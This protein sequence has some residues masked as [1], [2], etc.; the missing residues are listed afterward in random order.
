ML[1]LSITAYKLLTLN[2]G[3]ARCIG[4][5]TGEH[6]DISDLLRRIGNFNSAQL[7]DSVECVLWCIGRKN[8][9][10]TLANVIIKTIFAI[11]NNIINYSNI[12]FCAY[13]IN[14]NGYICVCI[15]LPP[16]NGTKIP[17]IKLIV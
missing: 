10:I 9:N 14:I 12:V 2:E 15:Y 4:D 16:D 17:Y 6:N 13:V 5:C 11:A 1:E 7:S 3:R 8:M